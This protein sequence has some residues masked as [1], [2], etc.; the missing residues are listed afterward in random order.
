MDK[1]SFWS[2]GLNY[3]VEPDEIAA[4]STGRVSGLAQI[5]ARL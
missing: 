5:S 1:K 2:L 4:G 3:Q